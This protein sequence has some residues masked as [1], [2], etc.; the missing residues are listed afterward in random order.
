MYGGTPA[1]VAAAVSAARLGSKVVLVTVHDQVGGVVSGGLSAADVGFTS[2]LRGFAKEFFR[3]ADARYG[4][5]GGYITE[6]HVAEDLFLTMLKSVH[7]N[8]VRRTRLATVAQASGTITALT[9]D[10]GTTIEAQSFIDATY[11]GDL[12]ATAG[13]P[14]T[15]GRESADEY[16]ERYAGVRP[17]TEGGFAGSLLGLPGGI[18][19][20]AAMGSSDRSPQAYTFRLTLT[21][22]P[23]AKV[24]FRRPPGYDASIYQPIVPY[25]VTHNLDPLVFKTP[26]RARKFDLNSKGLI[27]T[28]LV[29]AQDGWTEA[30]TAGRSALFTQHWHW[31][32]G[33]LW[34]MSSNP[35]VPRAMR[36]SINTYGL[37]ADE[38]IMSGGWSNALY[39]RESRRMLGRH[40]MTERDILE[41]H[42][43]PDAVASGSYAI[44]SH[45]VHR[46]ER[47]GITTTEGDL[48]VPIPRPYPIPYRVLQPP[49]GS[50]TNLQVPCALS[51]SHV[52][53]CSLRMEPTFM[54]LGQ[55]AGVAAASAVALRTAVNELP[56]AQISS[57]IYETMRA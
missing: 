49:S 3:A 54:M 14:W 22:D 15:I 26:L 48:F 52:A 6:P 8:V 20:P 37:C 36:D 34:F 32:A 55:V 13:V 28:N 12:M 2:T 5:T 30:D 31:I 56:F 9:F 21:N 19:E 23:E 39:V 43:V 33:L 29:G 10:N 17:L 42:S 41:E 4:T 47:D 24:P 38:F 16:G 40:I 50:V 25:L 53:F 51:A 35:S 57:R 1:G 11:E 18:T 27:S 46:V 44:D 45:P 7:V